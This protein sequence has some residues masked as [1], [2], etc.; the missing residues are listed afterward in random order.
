MAAPPA[1][2]WI[3]RHWPRD[4]PGVPLTRHRWLEILMVA[5]LVTYILGFTLLPSLNVIYV[6]LQEK[7][8]AAFP[9]LV[10]YRYIFERP[11]FA[12]TVLNT[13]VITIVGLALE[14]T[15]GM[16]IA[17]ILALLSQRV[18]PTM[19]YLLSGAGQRPRCRHL[20]YY[21]NDHG[22][23]GDVGAAIVAPYRLSCWGGEGLAWE[24]VMH[25]AGSKS[26]SRH[27]GWS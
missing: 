22:L 24:E 12:Q 15:A 16:I 13:L 4:I 10:N 21:P 20:C 6:S 27:S 2:S 1:I 9:T 18:L 7:G 19:A 11:R 17:I 25:G 3:R 8:G 14:M 5:P 23:P 26:P